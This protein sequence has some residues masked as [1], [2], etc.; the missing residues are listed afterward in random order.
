MFVCSVRLGTCLR[1]ACVCVVCAS[2]HIFCI[3]TTMLTS[4][5]TCRQGAHP[6]AVAGEAGVGNDAQQLSVGWA[7]EH[8]T[9]DK[10]Q[11]LQV[12]TSHKQVR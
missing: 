9:F 3:H 1:I 12:G 10:S 4:L 8:H 11:R 7:V 5:G 2:A 6:S